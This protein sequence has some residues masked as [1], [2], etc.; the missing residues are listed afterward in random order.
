VDAEFLP[1]T[2]AF[3]DTHISG[4]AEE[5]LSSFE[6]LECVGSVA[7]S[8]GRCGSIADKDNSVSCVLVIRNDGVFGQFYKPTQLVIILVFTPCTVGD[9]A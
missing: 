7:L 6:I 9:E 8:L 1:A 2:W 4:Q 5:F 3:P